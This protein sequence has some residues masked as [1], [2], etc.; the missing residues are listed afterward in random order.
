MM[1][2]SKTCCDV[3]GVCVCV[4][5]TVSSSSV[6][7]SEGVEFESNTATIRKDAAYRATT[8]LTKI[9]ATGIDQMLDDA[10]LTAPQEG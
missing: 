7:R 3:D 9:D 1:L 10:Q 5:P 8:I 4:C 2:T 6:C